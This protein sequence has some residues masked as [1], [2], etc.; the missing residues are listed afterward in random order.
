MSAVSRAGTRAAA[1]S[2]EPDLLRLAE[3]DDRV[4]A[5][6]VDG[7]PLPPPWAD[8][9]THPVIAIANSDDFIHQVNDFI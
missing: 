5:A 8:A 1:S 4:L 2:P 9:D 3:H 6:F 7:R